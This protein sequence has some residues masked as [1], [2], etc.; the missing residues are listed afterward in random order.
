MKIQKQKIFL[1]KKIKEILGI[2]FWLFLIFWVVFWEDIPETCSQTQQDFSKFLESYWKAIESIKSNSASKKPAFVVTEKL[3]PTEWIDLQAKLSGKSDI[4]A[5][6]FQNAIAWAWIINFLAP[7]KASISSLY[8]SV[9]LL[10][11]EKIAKREWQRALDLEQKNLDV[12]TDLSKKQLLYNELTESDLGQL[13][14]NLKDINLWLEI[15]FQPW[16]RYIDVI[17]F[18]QS[19][20]Y[21]MKMLVLY[22]TTNT[23]D[24]FDASKFL[25]M[26]DYQ[27]SFVSIK[28]N[29][30]TK[31]YINL[32]KLREI[33]KQYIDST[34]LS[35]KCP[36][37]LKQ[38]LTNFEKILQMASSDW[39]KSITR[40]NGNFNLLRQVFNRLMWKSVDQAYLDR[41]KKLR[42]QYGFASTA[43]N[44]LK[45]NLQWLDMDWKTLL[46]K[47]A[48]NDW[49]LPWSYVDDTAT[50]NQYNNFLIQEKKAF[51]LYQYG[52]PSVTQDVQA[53]FANLRGYFDK[54]I[55]RQNVTTL[56]A[57]EY[58]VKNI[59][60]KFP[61][62]SYNIYQ[63]IDAIWK[64]WD[65][66]DKWILPNLGEA[67]EL[68]CSN[69]PSKCRSTLN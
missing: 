57:V 33:K 59:T 4:P 60:F 20:S 23:Q 6:F 52:S 55:D 11:N 9:S 19:Y 51:Y 14:A 53:R 67:C 5:G 61:I 42:E 16:T 63:S 13:N 64:R 44:R 27:F 22:F 62:V 7:L 56:A 37:N 30:T 31:E 35:N 69:I 40:I 26:L 24:W 12:W 32:L 48:Q 28:Q 43:W 68:Q 17:N 54:W 50:A 47:Q 34:G 2:F 46:Q 45:F 15:T 58:N 49:K 66:Q 39:A 41:E 18:N 10:A 38:T 25:E 29:P 8:G 36:N 65:S 3:A 21:F 1:A